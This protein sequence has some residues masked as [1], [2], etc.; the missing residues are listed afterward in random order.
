[1]KGFLRNDG[2]VL[3]K[4]AHVTSLRRQKF[5]R[6]SPPGGGFTARWTIFRVL[7]TASKYRPALMD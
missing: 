1:V 5:F 6:H 4:E 3:L 2:V 7:P